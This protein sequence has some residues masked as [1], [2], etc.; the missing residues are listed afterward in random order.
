MP[1]NRT[2]VKLAGVGGVSIAYRCSQCSRVFPVSGG[3]LA[4]Q[5]KAEKAQA[6]FNK[7]NC[8]EDAS[9]AAARIVREAT[10]DK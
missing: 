9:Q 6:E 5:Q 1:K 3:P 4:D 8:H 2:L 7:H 10:E